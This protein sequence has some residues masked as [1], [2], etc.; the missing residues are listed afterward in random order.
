MPRSRELCSLN[1][2]A[3]Y[4]Q[5]RRSYW[6][7]WY[8]IACDDHGALPDGKRRQVS[9]LWREKISGSD[10]ETSAWD[11]PKCREALL[12]LRYHRMV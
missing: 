6:T 10:R 2:V 12:G 8:A 1:P 4:F 5:Y 9:P 3:P 11:G 7:S